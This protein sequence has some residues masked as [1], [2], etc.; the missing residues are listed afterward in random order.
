MGPLRTFSRRATRPVAFHDVSTPPFLDLPAGVRATEVGTPRGPLAALRAEPATAT[1]A[2]VLLVPGYTGSKEDFIAVLAPIAAAGHPVVAVDQ[3]GQYQ[4]PGD[5]EPSS[6]DVKVLADDVLA[7]LSGL[8]AGSAH[9]VGHSFGGLV[10]RAAALADARALRSLTLM[11]SGPAAVPPPAAT[12]IGL[13]A[14]ALPAIDLETIWG[15]KRQLE[16]ETEVDPPAADIEAWLH[17]RFVANHPVGLLRVAQQL[18][19]ET[20]RTDELARLDLPVLVAFGERDDVWPPAL[21]AA[22]AER[23]GARVAALP[24][25]GHSPAADAPEPTVAALLEFWSATA[26]SS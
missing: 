17:D 1:G 20:D 24:G 9:L 21:Q 26:P 8:G 13:L 10:A 16:A 4:T 19:T 22:T 25:V 2:P 3:R 12:N 23:L 7:V 11:S 18:L 14:Q 5:D 15:V 6:Y